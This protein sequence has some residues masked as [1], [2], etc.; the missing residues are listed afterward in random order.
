M[1]LF[2]F[3]LAAFFFQLAGKP[4]CFFQFGAGFSLFFFFLLLLLLPFKRKVKFIDFQTVIVRCYPDVH[5][6]PQF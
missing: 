6:L 4:L 1:R 5:H 2:L 3:K